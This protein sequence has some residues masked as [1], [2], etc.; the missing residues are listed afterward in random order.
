MPHKA[1]ARPVGPVAERWLTR[2]FTAPG[3]AFP[4]IVARVVGNPERIAWLLSGLESVDPPV[5]FGCAKALRLVAEREPRLVYPHFDFFVR[6]LDS[7][8]SVLRWNAAATLA[9]LGPAD[10]Q[11]KLEAILEKYLSVIDGPE[12]IAA[13]TAIQGAP[14]IAR[15]KPR[16]AGALVRAILRVS[17][18]R[19]KTDECRNVAI[20]HALKALAEI[21][22]AP[23]ERAAVLAFAKAQLENPRPA[24]RKKA[25]AF[26]RKSGGA[27]NLTKPTTRRRASP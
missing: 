17:A 27:A 18:A 20:G 11:N 7:P 13:A 6:Q 24:T 4:G 14:A 2:Q 26:L 12:M 5:K 16:L 15:A 23:D 22:N 1:Q 19:Y 10:R 9:R 25:E 8:N 3:G 21:G